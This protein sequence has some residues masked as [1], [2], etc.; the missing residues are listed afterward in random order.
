MELKN[1]LMD[2]EKTAEDGVVKTASAKKQNSSEKVSSARTELLGALNDILVAPGTTKTAADQQSAV[3]ELTK[4][5]SN[6]A[7]AD[8]EALVKEANFWGS[9]VA[10]GFVSRL[11]QHV[12]ATS[13]YATKTASADGIPTQAEF[14]KFAEENPDLVKQAIELGYY[15]GKAQLAE[16]QGQTKTAEQHELQQVFEKLAETPEGQE[17]LAAIERGYNDTMEKVAAVNQGY[18]DTARELVKMANDTF[19]R[20]YNDTIRILQNM[21]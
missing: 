6:L 5:A 21:A 16:L 14:E 19:T 18:N 8:V 12:D 9:A 10:D 11:N 15:H 7:N 20:G 17:K 4:M 3:G 1:I 2:L 13:S